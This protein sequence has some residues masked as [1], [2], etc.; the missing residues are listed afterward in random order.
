MVASGTA[1]SV[2]P[3]HR[4][5]D[6]LADGGPATAA[7]PIREGSDMSVS[8]R[9]PRLAR[10]LRPEHDPRGGDLAL[11]RRPAGVPPVRRP[12]P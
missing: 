10:R 8:E 9:A 5:A 7:D 2:R 1:R 11:W 12:P 3:P 4:F 6:P